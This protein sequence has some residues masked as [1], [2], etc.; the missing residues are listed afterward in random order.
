E[1]WPPP[2]ALA[3]GRDGKET[4]QPP[5][6]EPGVE[7]ARVHVRTFRA[8]GLLGSAIVLLGFLIV[9]GITIGLFTLA[10]GIGAAILA[11][12]AL[13]AIFGFGA[14]RVRRALR[15]RGDDRGGPTLPGA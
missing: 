6:R 7:A 3:T 5:A 15:A 13:A 4:W 1:S 2:D 12:T 9:L 10:I 8:R 14:A 11:G